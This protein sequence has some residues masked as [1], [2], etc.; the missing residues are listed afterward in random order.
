MPGSRIEEVLK[1]QF[2]HFKHVSTLS[3]AAGTLILVV[4]RY[5]PIDLLIL[6]LAMGFLMA[7]FALSMLGMM[8]VTYRLDAPNLD[9]RKTRMR[10]RQ[11]Q[12]TSTLCLLT[13]LTYFFAFVA[14]VP[15]WG[16]YIIAPVGLAIII[17]DLICFAAR[18]GSK[19]KAP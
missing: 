16:P 15:E 17:V 7:A 18:Y 9:N 6:L 3:V 8:A 13:G 10:P 1:L 2:D 4:Y 14:I 19:R 12:Q 5:F 11:L